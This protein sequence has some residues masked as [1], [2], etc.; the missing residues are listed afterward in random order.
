MGRLKN[1]AL[2]IR[3]GIRR[4]KDKF[5]TGGVIGHIVG[6]TLKKFG[7]KLGGKGGRIVSTLGDIGLGAAGIAG[8]LAGASG[9]LRDAGDAI[10][11]KGGRVVSTLGDIASGG[12]AG[13]QIYRGTTGGF[14]SAQGHLGNV[15]HNFAQNIGTKTKFGKKFRTLDDKLTSLRDD[16]D[17]LSNM[18]LSGTGLC[19]TFVGGALCKEP[20]NHVHVNNDHGFGGQLRPAE[21]RLGADVAL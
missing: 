6:S 3:S 12:R 17:S 18:V 4:H 16:P 13:V 21:P 1:G 19:N 20:A 5:I 11:G 7:D 2:G 9:T 15:L 10:G 8:E 14:D